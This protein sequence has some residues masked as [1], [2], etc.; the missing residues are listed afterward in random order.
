MRYVQVCDET[1][2]EH[3]A[4]I[5]NSQHYKHITMCSVCITI[6]WANKEKT[7]MLAEKRKK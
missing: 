5:V 4:L 2:S 1:V 3:S 6:K 7:K